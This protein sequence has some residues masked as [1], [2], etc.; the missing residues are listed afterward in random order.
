[1]V[2]R[3]IYMECGYIEEHLEK[4]IKLTEF[5]ESFPLNTFRATTQKSL[6]LL[7]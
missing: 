6:S 1:M 5:L 2:Y 3:S 4:K 7:Q